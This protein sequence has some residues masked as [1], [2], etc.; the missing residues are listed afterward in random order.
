METII[1]TAQSLVLYEVLPKLMKEDIGPPPDP[2]GLAKRRLT[3]LFCAA[4]LDRLV[5]D[6]P[7]LC[8]DDFLH[9]LFPLLDFPLAP[10]DDIVACAKLFQF[11]RSGGRLVIFDRID[12]LIET[13]FLLAQRLLFGFH[14]FDW[15]PQFDGLAQHG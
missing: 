15:R 4:A 1:H 10:T 2:M 6:L 8:L 3:Q 7:Q 5:D 14:G 12:A 13:L 9:R 11:A